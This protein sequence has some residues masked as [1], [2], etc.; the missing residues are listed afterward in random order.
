M[1]DSG[2]NGE[3]D[4]TADF[5]RLLLTPRYR[6]FLEAAFSLSDAASMGQLSDPEAFSTWALAVANEIAGRPVEKIENL[7]SRDDLPEITAV[8]L[9]AL[10]T[11]LKYRADKGQQ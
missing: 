10:G 1:D 8:A 5:E 4:F 3:N 2:R 9:N 6:A 7:I 11:G